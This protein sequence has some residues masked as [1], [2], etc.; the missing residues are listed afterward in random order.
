MSFDWVQ[1]QKVGAFLRDNEVP[2][3]SKEARERCF[4]SR[5]YYAV[6]GVARGRASTLY[7][8]SFK[9]NAEDHQL[10]VHELKSHGQ[11]Q[12]AGRIRDLRQL[13]NDADY[14]LDLPD[15]TLKADLA[16]DITSKA[17]A[18]LKELRR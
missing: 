4:I 7:R 5:A 9:Q 6:F 12:L 3:A 16:A 11:S 15:C 13:R 10:L 1:F 18:K 14:S 17:L 2:D 8:V